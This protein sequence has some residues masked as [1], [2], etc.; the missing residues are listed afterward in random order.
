MRLLFISSAIFVFLWKLEF[1][2]T[3]PRYVSKNVQYTEY[4]CEIR[5]EKCKDLTTIAY[6]VQY[7]CFKHYIIYLSGIY[8]KISV[9]IQRHKNVANICLKVCNQTSYALHSLQRFLENICR[10]TGL[11]RCGFQQAHANIKSGILVNLI[12]QYKLFLNYVVVQGR[13]TLYSHISRRYQG[14]D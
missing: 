2:N 3:V 7:T 14:H 4:R 10:E 11:C 13:I 6:T 5:Y 9:R 8:S 1:V 12:Y